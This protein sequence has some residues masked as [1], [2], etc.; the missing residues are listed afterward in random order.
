[1]CRAERAHTSDRHRRELT[2][3]G[4]ALTLDERCTGLEEER[5]KTTR[6]TAET[7]RKMQGSSYAPSTI[8][9]LFPPQMDKGPKNRLPQKHQI[10]YYCIYPK[11]SLKGPVQ[12]CLSVNMSMRGVIPGCYP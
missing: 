2:N 6:R 1:M 5:V 4:E 3:R 8:L 11:A 9:A 7:Q 10:A 12:E